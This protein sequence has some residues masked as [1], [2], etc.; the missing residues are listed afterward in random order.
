MATQ[1][2]YYEVNVKW[3]EGRIG[4][5]SAP[6]LNDSI[7]CATPPE[8]AGGV[9]GI[10][11]PEHLYAAS[12]NSCYM[13]TF[14]AIADNFKLAFEGFE[15]KTTCKLQMVEN[16]YQ[17]THAV[18][19]PEVILKNPSADTD[20]LNR[21]LEKAKAACLVTNSIKTIIELK[22]KQESVFQ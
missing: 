11:S 21:I 22:P 7:T 2:H 6:G 1:E 8:F 3:K 20:K 9:P 19:E 13:A 17:I 16:R 5:L 15:C 14:L 18:I 10:W 4:Q 12:V